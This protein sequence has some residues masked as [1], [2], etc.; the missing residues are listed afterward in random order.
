MPRKTPDIEV[1][2]L[3]GK[4]AI[5]TGASDGLGL[6]LAERLA[7]A[8]AEVIMPVRNRAKGAA[9]VERI[10]A[11]V[12]AAKVSSRELDL[13]SLE[14]VAKFAERLT[15][16]GRPIDILINNAG[17]MTPPDRQVTDDGLELQFATNHLGHFALTA[18]IFPL[19]RDGGARVTSQTSI[20]AKQ[21][22][23]LWDDLQ[24]ERGYNAAKA[25][26]SSKIALALFAMELDRRARASGWGIESNVSHP[27]VAPTN[28]LA[29]HP[30]MGRSKD[31]LAVR[32]IRS[33]SRLG[34]LVGTPATGLLPALYGATSPEAEG[35][36]FYGPDGFLHLSGA[37]AEQ[38]PYK[39]FADEA[40]A[41]RMWEISEEVGGSSIRLAGAPA[42]R[43]MSSAV[44]PDHW[45][46]VADSPVL[47]VHPD[48]RTV[49][50]VA[51]IDRVL[52]HPAH[53]GCHATLRASVTSG[54]SP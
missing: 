19:L 8:G 45:I 18:Q 33:L 39:S 48:D 50:G 10:A 16:E 9:A 5:V 28:L 25:Y 44:R 23:I 41:E 30:E 14:S 31:T 3:D 4:L 35:G 1:P 43:P 12:P 27:G 13:A 54:R 17:L 38:E 47:T 7:R 32:V 37:P 40:D 24:S 52:Q 15:Q 46:Q 36:K 22:G 51:E 20:A 53:P 6:G 26:S 21:H 2:R 49:D 34:V 29:A 42:G 11:A